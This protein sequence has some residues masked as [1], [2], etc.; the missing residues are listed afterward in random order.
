MWNDPFVSLCKYHIRRLHNVHRLMFSLWRFRCR[1]VFLPRNNNGY[2]PTVWPQGL[3][4]IASVVLWHSLRQH[5]SVNIR[6][7]FS[8]ATYWSVLLTFVANDSVKVWDHESDLIIILRVTPCFIMLRPGF[9][10]ILWCTYVADACSQTCSQINSFSDTKLYLRSYQPNHEFQFVHD[11]L[12]IIRHCWVGDVQ[13][14]VLFDIYGW[15]K[16]LVSD[17][18]M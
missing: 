11:A 7:Q 18:N 16:L 5:L 9:R 4:L 2:A 17:N 14:C 8:E 1:E 13:A 6:P 12:R 15:R 10:C 3:L